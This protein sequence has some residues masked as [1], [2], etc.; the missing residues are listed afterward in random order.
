ME[1]LNPTI[2]FDLLK[3]SA[4]DVFARR[5][6]QQDRHDK[7]WQTLALALRHAVAEHVRDNCILGESGCQCCLL[8]P[9]EVTEAEVRRRLLAS[10]MQPSCDVEAI[11]KAKLEDLP[12]RMQASRL[13]KKRG[14]T[15]SGTYIH[16]FR[17]KFFR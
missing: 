15:G 6:A 10:Y 12:S 4:A 3:A 1:S 2:S 9:H 13:L 14:N 17:R 11:L 7:P 5:I 8:L 16:N